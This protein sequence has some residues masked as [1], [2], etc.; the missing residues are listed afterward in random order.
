MFLRATGWL[1]VIVG[2]IVLPP[3]LLKQV[4]LVRCKLDD[5]LYCMKT[6]SKVTLRRSRQVCSRFLLLCSNGKLIT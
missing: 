3:R 2:L 1:V 6:M 5:R 4:D